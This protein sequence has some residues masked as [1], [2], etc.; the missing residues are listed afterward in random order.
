M[1]FN[2]VLREQA[3]WQLTASGPVPVCRGVR[4]TEPKRS[5]SKKGG[6]RSARPIAIESSS[7]QIGLVHHAHGVLNLGQGLLGDLVG[8]TVALVQDVLHIVQI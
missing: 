7:Q 8:A 6:R 1:R 3:R 5:G 4:W 2:G